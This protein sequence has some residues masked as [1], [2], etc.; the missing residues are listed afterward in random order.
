MVYD[1]MVV[2][3]TE[4]PATNIKNYGYPAQH[5]ETVKIF[6]GTAS[7]ICHDLGF[8]TATGQRTMS[9][10]SAMRCITLL[11]SG[12]PGFPSIYLLHYKPTEEQYKKYKSHVSDQNTYVKPSKYQ[13]LISDLNSLRETLTSQ[14]KM[15]E[16][17]TKRVDSLEGKGQHG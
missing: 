7:R 2:Q 8:T 16:D 10:L 14:R 11:K 4:E 17:L 6:R 13:I 15:I 12:G 1:S 9:L 3:S 5:G